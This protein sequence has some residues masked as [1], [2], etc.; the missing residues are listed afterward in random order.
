[1]LVVRI[2]GDGARR[3]ERLSQQ[4]GDGKARN[5]YSR[6]INDEG[7]KAATYTGRA[8]AKQTGLKARV[9]REALKKRDRASPSSLMFTIKVQ[10]GNIRV[11]YFNPREN[12]AGVSATPW[13]KRV[14]YA[15]AF[16]RAGFWP[17]RVDKGNWNGQVF[18][19]TGVR[20][21][22]KQYP[23]GN[24]KFPHGMDQFKVARSGVYIP[25]EATQGRTAEVFNKSGQALEIRVTHYL[26]R[27]SQ[28]ALS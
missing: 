28:G 16:M 10:G 7:A 26:K 3:F 8:L 21:F 6:A 19:R 2:A 1:M 23:K 20:K 4:L 12:D 24:A 9:T 22:T 14:T 27:L 18:Y 5:V 13:N 15:G 11:K 25:I 17:Q